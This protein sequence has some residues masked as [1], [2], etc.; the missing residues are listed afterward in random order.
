[1][2]QPIPSPHP[3]LE[4]LGLP[5]KQGYPAY[6]GWG[7][8]VHEMAGEWTQ[9]QQY[10]DTYKQLPWYQRWWQRLKSQ[11]QLWLPRRWQGSLANNII[12][13]ERQFATCCALEQA[14][15]VSEEPSNESTNSAN[16]SKVM[17]GDLEQ[18]EDSAMPS[19]QEVAT[20]AVTKERERKRQACADLST[21]LA[22]SYSH[23][24]AIVVPKAVVG[25][26]DADAETIETGPESDTMSVS[27]DESSANAAPA[28]PTVEESAISIEGDIQAVITSTHAKETVVKRFYSCLQ[29]GY[30]YLLSGDQASLK[31][32]DQQL[33][34]AM[35]QLVRVAKK[36]QAVV[37]QAQQATEDFFA[38]QRQPFFQQLFTLVAKLQKAHSNM[39]KS[40]A[41]TGN[42]Y[43]EDIR[44]LGQALTA[45]AAWVSLSANEE[46]QVRVVPASLV[47]ALSAYY[48]PLLSEA[49]QHIK[50]VASHAQ[51]YQQQL[52]Q[53]YKQRQV[54]APTLTC[55]TDVAEAEEEQL[56]LLQSQYEG[57]LTV[58]RSL[59]THLLHQEFMDTAEEW[60]KQHNAEYQ[61]A[62]RQLF[63]QR[64][65]QLL[66]KKA[67]R[68]ADF[69]VLS[70]QWDKALY[71][72][73]WDV[74][75]DI[76]YEN[77]V[78]P[79]RLCAFVEVHAQG[80][81][82]IYAE[83]SL[84]NKYAKTFKVKIKDTEES[85]YQAITEEYYS[86]WHNFKQFFD[87]QVL[88]YVE[89]MLT[90]Q[91]RMQA[92]ANKKWKAFN[93]LF[94]DGSLHGQRLPFAELISTGER[95]RQTALAKASEPLVV[96]RQQLD[97][98]Y[99]PEDI[100]PV[101]DDEQQ[102]GMVQLELLLELE[103]NEQW[104]A[105]RK[106]CKESEL[107]DDWKRC[108]N[109]ISHR[110]WS[111]ASIFG[112]RLRYASM[113]PPPFREIE[114]AVLAAELDEHHMFFYVRFGREMDRLRYDYYFGLWVMFSQYSKGQL[115]GD[116][117]QIFDEH[118]REIKAR[119]RA[120][121]LFY[122]P[123]KN[124][125]QSF[126][127]KY[128]D[129]WEK[130]EAAFKRE[131]TRSQPKGF[132]SYEQ[133]FTN[134]VGQLKK[135]KQS[136]N[137]NIAEWQKRIPPSTYMASQPQLVNLPWNELHD[138]CYQ[139]SGFGR[140]SDERFCRAMDLSL[141]WHRRLLP[142]IEAEWEWVPLHKTEDM[143]WEWERYLLRF[144][145]LRRAARG[146]KDAFTRYARR[147][148]AE[149]TTQQTGHSPGFFQGAGA[150]AA[151]STTSSSQKK[152]DTKESPRSSPPLFQQFFNA[153]GQAKA[154]EEHNL[155]QRR[156][157]NSI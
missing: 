134:I 54:E 105:L 58:A 117:T 86:E 51:N 11:V 42:A 69:S 16:R 50:D 77:L 121:T 97:K 115:R 133:Q 47:T 74:D 41:Y 46:V 71:R 87:A 122:H 27:R 135:F 88:P 21:A 131:D 57:I 48:S 102:M 111:A 30:E 37:S 75:D 8:W 157:R 3:P 55:F 13:R 43:L 147:I 5:A 104:S 142:V 76:K 78:E 31:Q 109:K 19:K 92:L 70:K 10:I 107:T 150:S 110:A 85:R 17:L 90:A 98:I 128:G 49:K 96:S 15:G 36:N 155:R 139:N 82:C 9:L 66:S 112:K 116:L 149:K 67:T 23:L 120:L 144:Y 154:A 4:Y 94:T 24:S 143:Q 84:R 129:A 123:D 18:K 68:E 106:A 118:V 95:A 89:Q 1:M 81:E 64:R 91:N 29:Q 7:M 6:A 103:V 73:Y 22:E 20:V 53:N 28:E 148:G 61:E 124:F 60:L 127:Q 59:S 26:V 52:E 100:R 93:A 156:R 153:G 2:T 119:V 80:I 138:G 79:E 140:E 141:A 40:Q 45:D 113:P 62:Y 151:A 25:G 83:L 14:W 38:C 126:K 33:T 132:M 72:F 35:Q 12:Y 39:N 146:E 63:E 101:L 108:V 130:A 114:D 32:H 99:R 65:Q 136:L 34:E 137:G 152:K 44:T 56:Q 125:Y 145:S